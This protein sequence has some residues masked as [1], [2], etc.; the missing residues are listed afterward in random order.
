MR[1]LPKVTSPQ[2]RG[3]FT[4]S[5]V[6]RNTMSVQGVWRALLAPL[7]EQNCALPNE[8][9]QKKHADSVFCISGLAQY[10]LL[11]SRPGQS[12]VLLYKHLCLSLIIYWLFILILF[13]FSFYFYNCR[14][15]VLE[16][17]MNFHCFLFFN[18]LLKNIPK[19][20]K[21]IYIYIW[22][23]IT[24]DM[25]HVS[26]ANKYSHSPTMNC[27]SRMASKAG[28][29]E[30]SNKMALK[31]Y[32]YLHLCHFPS[33]NTFRYSFLDFLS[34]EYIKIFVCKFLEIWIYLNICSEPYF[35]ICLSIFNEKY[36]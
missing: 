26:N 18:L 17:T 33:M 5:S 9:S 36:I 7:G 32:S 29:F 8:L 19:N 27:C 20:T 31:D 30:Y 4:K 28:I 10:D 3:F 1:K 11:I 13:F 15:T 12:Q 2:N 22:F 35:H 34:T 24:Y 23:I 6:S 25:S 14:L 16:I 21:N